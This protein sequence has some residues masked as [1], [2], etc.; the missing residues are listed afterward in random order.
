MSI[1]VLPGS[2]SPAFTGGK[3]RIVAADAF[4]D[5]DPGEGN[6]IKLSVASDGQI[7]NTIEILSKM[8]SF[9]SIGMEK[10]VHLWHTRFLDRTGVWSPTTTLSFYVPVT[11]R[12][13]QFILVARF[14]ANSTWSLREFLRD[15]V[16]SLL[17]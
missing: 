17:E 14:A 13:K 5:K 4:I 10:G 6:G 2:P 15:S 7:E 3:N 1:Y 12:K 11:I 16:S 9:Y 8:L